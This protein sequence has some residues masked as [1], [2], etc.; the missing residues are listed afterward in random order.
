[1]VKQDYITENFARW[2]I[3]HLYDEISEI[4]QN[5]GASD[6][7]TVYRS[8]VAYKRVEQVKELLTDES[9]KY[10]ESWLDYEIS[11]IRMMA[12]CEHVYNII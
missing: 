8:K 2:I 3:N 6:P 9:W 11:F 1:M 10:V 7:T 5:L 4:S 12:T